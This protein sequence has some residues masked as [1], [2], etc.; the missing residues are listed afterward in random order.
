MLDAI[1]EGMINFESY[2]FFRRFE[3]VVGK[4]IRQ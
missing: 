1:K 2:Y 4:N 3:V